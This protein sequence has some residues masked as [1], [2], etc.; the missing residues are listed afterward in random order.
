M[1]DPDFLLLARRCIENDLNPEGRDYIPL[2]VHALVQTRRPWS[3][4][5]TPLFPQELEE[6]LPPSITAE[7][8]PHVLS[9]LLDAFGDHRSVFL[10][11]GRVPGIEDRKVTIFSTTTSQLGPEG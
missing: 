4:R 8:L 6:R 10:I 2:A 7:S 1:E 9:K 5:A 11:R 3:E